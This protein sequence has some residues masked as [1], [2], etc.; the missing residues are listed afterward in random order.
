MNNVQGSMAQIAEGA[1]T[2]VRKSE[3]RTIPLDAK[4]LGNNL[5]NRVIAKIKADL[6][7]QKKDAELSE[8]EKLRKEVT[9]IATDA[10]VAASRDAVA[11][12][13]SQ[14]GTKELHINPQ[15]FGSDISLSFSDPGWICLA[16]PSATT[17]AT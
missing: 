17:Q 15:P 1:L 3:V 4:M 14:T 2:P 6:E 10:A 7:Q 9:E 8:V 13:T 11:Q 12:V 16:A 5:A